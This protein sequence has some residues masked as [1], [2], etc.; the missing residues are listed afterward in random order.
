VPF[1]WTKVSTVGYQARDFPSPWAWIQ[2]DGGPADW[3]AT[4]AKKERELVE[5]RKTN[6]PT[7]LG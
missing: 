1:P 3:K 4:A 7:S 2:G 6:V 5:L